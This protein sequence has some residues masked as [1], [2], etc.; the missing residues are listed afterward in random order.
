M[1]FDYGQKADYAGQLASMNAHAFLFDSEIQPAE[2]LA[3]AYNNRCFAYM[4][5]GE[6]QK[7][8]DD[9]TL[10]LKYG[11]IPDA[12]HKQQ[13]LLKLLGKTP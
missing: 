10:S 7:A 4:K 1:S 6:L 12:L 13:E 9:C 8:L 5:L 2:D 3:P 11:R